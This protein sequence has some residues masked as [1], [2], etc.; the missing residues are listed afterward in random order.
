MVIRLKEDIIALYVFLFL[1]DRVFKNNLLV[2]F[3]KV[4]ISKIVVAIP[5]KYLFKNISTT[6]LLIYY[7]VN[8]KCKAVNDTYLRQTAK[9][10]T[11]F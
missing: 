11:L 2:V 8:V 5:L 6:L 3:M 4:K 10:Y 7:T 1:I 9:L